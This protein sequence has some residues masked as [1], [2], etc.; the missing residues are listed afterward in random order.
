MSAGFQEKRWEGWHKAN[1]ISMSSYCQ[2]RGRYELALEL[3]EIGTEWYE[4][5]VVNNA[6]LGDTN[7]HGKPFTQFLEEYR[8][9]L[10]DLQFLLATRSRLLETLNGFADGIERDRLKAMVKHEGSTSFGVI[11][12]QLARG[13][14]L[15]QQKIGKK[16]TVYPERTA[17]VSDDEFVCTEMRAPDETNRPTAMT[18]ASEVGVEIR[19]DNELVDSGP[20][21]GRPINGDGTAP[22]TEEIDAEVKKWIAGEPSKLTVKVKTPRA[23]YKPE[24]GSDDEYEWSSEEDRL[25]YE[26]EYGG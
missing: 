6:R 20:I 21:V 11:C 4:R 16:H 18:D 24:I 7:D 9:R 2:A 1:A 12:N 26:R 10:A 8:Q 3:C 13:G 23:P 5:E 17:P 14:W 25:E 19:E 22:T 15:R